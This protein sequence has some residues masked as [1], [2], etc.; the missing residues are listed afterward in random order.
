MIGLLAITVLWMLAMV[1][2]AW[3]YF[4]KQQQDGA[5][6]DRA[7]R[8]MLESLPF[9]NRK[10]RR[11]ALKMLRRRNRWERMR[12]GFGSWFGL[13]ARSR[14]TYSVGC[15]Q[16]GQHLRFTKLSTPDTDP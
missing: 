1:A 9:M 12:Q 3:R 7:T 15:P 5:N 6:L 4:V 14:Q 2:A 8:A 16:H 10:H 11:A 13:T